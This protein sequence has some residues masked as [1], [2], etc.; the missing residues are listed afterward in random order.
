[1]EM[2]Q[3][4]TLILIILDANTIKIYNLTKQFMK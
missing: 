3:K 2:P 4:C 1:M